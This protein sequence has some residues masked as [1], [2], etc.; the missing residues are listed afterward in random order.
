MYA[1][2]NRQ[3][4]ASVLTNHWLKG[5]LAILIWLGL[6]SGCSWVIAEYLVPQPLGGVLWIC[7]GSGLL[8]GLAMMPYN[9]VEAAVISAI[10]LGLAVVPSGPLAEK[11]DLP[12]LADIAVSAIVTGYL[13]SRV[14]RIEGRPRPLACEAP[15]NSDGE[16]S[17]DS[18]D[19][20][21]GETVGPQSDGDANSSGG[22]GELVSSADGDSDGD[23]D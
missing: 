13:A 21:G 15:V 9:E 22:D 17:L 18:T 19:G 12:A 1:S 3:A 20:A 10:L 4:V 23:P 8:A 2:Q 16:A 11:L 6:G 7:L 14:V 5:A